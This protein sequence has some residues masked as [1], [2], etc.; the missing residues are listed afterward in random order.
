MEPDIPENTTKENLVEYVFNELSII[1]KANVSIM[2]TGEIISLSFT[3]MAHTTIETQR[4]LLSILKVFKYKCDD[5]KYVYIKLFNDNSG[6][7]DFDENQGIIFIARMKYDI[8]YHFFE[9]KI[10]LQTLWENIDFFQPPC[11][12]NIFQ[13]VRKINFPFNSQIID[14]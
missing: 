11:L 2:I 13:T 4:E 10:S 7:I 14:L 12:S 9:K 1:Y 5:I 6:S 8:I 3:P